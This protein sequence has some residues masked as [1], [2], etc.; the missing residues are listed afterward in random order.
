MCLIN[1]YY[2]IVD[3][4]IKGKFIVF[5]NYGVEKI[6][7]ARTKLLMTHDEFAKH[8]GMS[9]KSFQNSIYNKKVGFKIA[10]II[11]NKILN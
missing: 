8:I 4:P 9:R 6:E 11:I 7:N 3:N 5:N 1:K 10:K 2:D